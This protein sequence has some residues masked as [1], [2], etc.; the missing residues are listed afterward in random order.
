MNRNYDAVFFDFDGTVADTSR[1]IFN[2]AD[3]AARAFGL[4]V[5]DEAGHRYFM[6]PPL[7]ESF[8]VV[9]GLK[10]EDGVEAVKKYREYY[11]AGGMLEMEFYPGMIDFLKKLQL[12]GVRTAVTSSKPEMFVSQILEHFEIADLFNLIACP[13]SDSLPEKKASLIT[14][15]LQHFEIAPSRA[16]MVGDRYLDMQGAKQTGVDGCGAGWG[17]G[18]REELLDSGAKYIASSVPEL[19]R[20][21]FGI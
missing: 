20:I 8:D 13:R 9:M 16:L 5:P 15:A 12:G 1:G 6:G 2:S 18:T 7:L 4:P 17:Y 11:R 19:D 14:R 3:Y 21:V 10:G